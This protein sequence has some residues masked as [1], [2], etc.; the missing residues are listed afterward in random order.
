MN[1]RLLRQALPFISL[2]I[3][4]AATFY[5]QPRTMSYFGLNLMLQY[6]VPIALATIAQMFVI[7]VNDL[8]LQRL[9]GCFVQQGRYGGSVQYIDIFRQGVAAV[10]HG[11]DRNA[12]AAQGSHSLPDG[13]AAHAQPSGQLLTGDILSPCA[14]QRCENFLFD[15]TA[16]PLQAQL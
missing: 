14:V 2:A 5:V 16:A 7:A 12:V 11:L 6:A 1:R 13:G 9:Q 4:L 3:V 15:H 8:D 10:R